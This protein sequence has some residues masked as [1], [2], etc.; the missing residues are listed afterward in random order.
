MKHTIKLSLALAFFWWFNSGHTSVL[1][2][3]LAAIS[4]LFVLFIAHRMDAIDQDPVSIP[5]SFKIP[6]YFLWLTKE[7]ILANLTVAKHIILGA[8]SISPT[9]T[10]IDATQKTDFGKVAYA[11]SITLTPGTISVALEDDQI[12]VHALLS[13]SIDDLKTG[14]MD[15]RVTQV[16]S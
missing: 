8:K 7:V 9:M 16:E 11:N 1:M 14:E 15:R 4:I 6:G 13:E 12:L 3:S 2:L 5:L 10:L